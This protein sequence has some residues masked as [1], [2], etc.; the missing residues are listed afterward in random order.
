MHLAHSR[1]PREVCHVLGRDAA[2]GQDRDSFLRLRD[3]ALEP[4]GPVGRGA[5]AA[6]CQNT[7]N[8]ETNQDLERGTQVDAFVE[9]AMKCHRQRPRCVEQLTHSAFG[10]LSR[11]VQLPGHDPVRSRIFRA[12]NLVEEGVMLRI[13]VDEVAGPRTREDEYGDGELGTGLT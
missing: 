1:P 3:Q 2:A 10:D 12:L 9:G 13:G 4:L 6:G 11:I 7:V 8:A 5:R